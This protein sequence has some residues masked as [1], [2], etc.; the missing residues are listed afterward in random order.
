MKVRNV[1]LNSGPCTR[2]NK[3]KPEILVLL[4]HVRQ[5]PHNHRRLN[6]NPEMIY[7]RRVPAWVG[8]V[9][10]QMITIVLLSKRRPRVKIA[11]SLQERWNGNWYLMNYWFVWGGGVVVFQC[12]TKWRLFICVLAIYAYSI[13]F[14]TFPFMDIAEEIVQK[15]DKI[16]HSIT[17]V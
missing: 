2:I 4:Y 13:S 6:E 10:N 15:I 7:K 9:F 17:L 5:I 16:F 14:S 12:I 11:H 3:N 1:S 8:G